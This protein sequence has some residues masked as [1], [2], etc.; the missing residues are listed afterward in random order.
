[1]SKKSKESFDTMKTQLVR[2]FNS[3]IGKK[4]KMDTKEITQ[5]FDDMRVH[6]EYLKEMEEID[7]GFTTKLTEEKDEWWKK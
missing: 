2:I 3:L 6:T 7:A 5:A 4:Q 1:M